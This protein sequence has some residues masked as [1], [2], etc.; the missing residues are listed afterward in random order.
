MEFGGINKSLTI[1]SDAQKVLVACHVIAKHSERLSPNGLWPNI[2]PVK[3]HL[4]TRKNP[5]MG[6]RR[7]Q[8]LGD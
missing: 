3:L 4:E 1:G 2:D 8:Q 6:I 5:Y 7:L